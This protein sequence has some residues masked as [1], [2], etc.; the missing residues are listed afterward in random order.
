MAHSSASARLVNIEELLSKRGLT[1]GEAATRLSQFFPDVK[2]DEIASAL[3]AA[4]AKWDKEAA[5]R[6]ISDALLRTTVHFAIAT[7]QEAT[8]ASDAAIASL[9]T[10]LMAESSAAHSD[11]Q[12]WALSDAPARFSRIED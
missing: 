7:K 3:S 2:A 1:R 10:R 9:D 12:A 5:A 6:N 4:G 11:H 8:I